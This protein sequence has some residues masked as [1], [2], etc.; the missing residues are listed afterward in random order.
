[1]YHKETHGK[2]TMSR[3]T[4]TYLLVIVGLILAFM[5]ADGIST[6][7]QSEKINTLNKKITKIKK[8]IENSKKKNK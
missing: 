1:M 4:N 6:H 7:N 2:M 8:L 3:I 5:I